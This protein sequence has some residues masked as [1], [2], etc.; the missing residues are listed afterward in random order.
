[1]QGAFSSRCGNTLEAA[2]LSALHPQRPIYTSEKTSVVER[3]K[4][5]YHIS[6]AHMMGVI[7]DGQGPRVRI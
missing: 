3:A 4:M 2:Y 6:R 5:R 1:M 7:P